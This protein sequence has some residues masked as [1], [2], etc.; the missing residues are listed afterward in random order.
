MTD[1]ALQYT[2][3]FSDTT[4]T[5]VVSDD[6]EIYHGAPVGVQLVARKFEEEKIP[7]IAGIVT[8]ALETCREP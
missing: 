5:V 4:L 1:F 7:A 6:P 2:R 8:S 3:S